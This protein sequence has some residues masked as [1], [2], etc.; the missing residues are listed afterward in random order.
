MKCRA[1]E[2]GCKEWTRGARRG[3]KKQKKERGGGVKKKEEGENN[4]PDVVRG[5]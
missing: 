1:G 3:R 5:V 2:A 4:K